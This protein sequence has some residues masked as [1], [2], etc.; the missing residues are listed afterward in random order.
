M[1]ASNTLWDVLSH[2][3]DSDEEMDTVEGGQLAI[4]N[5]DGWYK[6]T[7]K[8]LEALEERTRKDIDVVRHFLG[9]G[10]YH[11]RMAQFKANLEAGLHGPMT[12]A[13][14]EEIYDGWAH[15]LT[16]SV[17][18]GSWFRRNWLDKL[19]KDLPDGWSTV[20]GLHFEDDEEPWYAPGDELL[21]FDVPVVPSYFFPVP[22][23]VYP[24]AP[25]ACTNSASVK[26]LQMS[27]TALLIDATSF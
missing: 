11:E 14:V 27:A 15:E 10:H 23:D 18:E 20:P 2:P 7:P 16:I 4:P 26:L 3:D 13:K 1:V 5:K 22:K 17:T 24:L 9:S 12:P 25:P 21:Q 8:L 6:R 19:P